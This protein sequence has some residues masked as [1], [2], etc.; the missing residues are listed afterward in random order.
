MVPNI[1]ALV[2]RLFTEHSDPPGPRVSW[3]LTAVPRCK[4]SA[5]AERPWKSLS[6]PGNQLVGLCSHAGPS[7]YHS[8]S[9]HDC[10]LDSPLPLLGKAGSDLNKHAKAASQVL[11]DNNASP[12]EN[13]RKHKEGSLRRQ[14]FIPV[15]AEKS[16]ARSS[17]REQLGGGDS[18]CRDLWQEQAGVSFLCWRGREGTQCMGAEWRQGSGT[19]VRRE[20]WKARPSYRSFEGLASGPKVVGD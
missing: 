11:C 15:M 4:A 17:G 3:A 1:L 10:E 6:Y 16:S 19:V 12:G 2:L 9:D 8:L 13:F 7:V 14:L 18:K 5:L 20:V